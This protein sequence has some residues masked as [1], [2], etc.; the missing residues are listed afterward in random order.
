MKTNAVRV[1]DRLGISY[2]APRLC[3]RS[4]RLR[5]KGGPDIGLPPEQVF[6][7]LL[8]RGD[9]SGPLLAVVPGDDEL[10]LKSLARLTTT[11]RSRWCRSRTCRD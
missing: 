4:R 10:D 1:L 6:K 9:R 7:T 3:G 11:A 8:V 5:R 2:A